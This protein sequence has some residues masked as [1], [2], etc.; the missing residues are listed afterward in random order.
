M[1]TN[2]VDRSLDVAGNGAATHRS[3]R[4]AGAVLLSFGSLC[5][6]SCH[7]LPPLG[8]GIAYGF[9]GSIALFGKMDSEND[10]HKA[11]GVEWGSSRKFFDGCRTR[12]RP[13]PVTT[14]WKYWLSRWRRSCAEPRPA[15]TWRSLDRP[16]KG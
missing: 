2:V 8:R 6:Q 14:W 5:A 13:M 15:R 12:G 4:V 1:R 16:R 7:A 11:E 10:S 3:I 9:S